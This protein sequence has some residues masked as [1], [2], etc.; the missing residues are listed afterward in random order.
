MAQPW[1][2][3]DEISRWYGYLLDDGKTLRNRVGATTPD[4]LRRA[5]DHLVETR[6]LS[7]REHGLPGSY[8]LAGLQ[9]VHRHMFQD[10]YDWAGELRTVSIRKSADTW[11]TPVPD[12]EPS[13]K[14]SPVTCARPTTCARSTPST[15]RVRS[16]P[17]T[18]S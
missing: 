5:E 3:G 16:P 14:C 15:C 6:A 8:D 9:A 18:T 10:V 1:E 2:T 13:W 11:F 7:L 4:D 12:I 17:S